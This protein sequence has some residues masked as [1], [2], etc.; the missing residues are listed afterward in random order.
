[1]NAVEALSAITDTLYDE[2]RAPHW[3]PALEGTS[4]NR[5]REE[6]Q[7]ILTDAEEVKKDP[8]G[9]AE[10][11]EDTEEGSISEDQDD[12]GSEV[13]KKATRLANRY[14]KLAEP[15]T[16]TQILYVKELVKTLA[17]R[18]TVGLPNPAELTTMSKADLSILIDKLK[19][20]RG[21]PV[22]IHGVFSHFDRRG[23]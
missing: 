23:N 17:Q 6:V 7:S 8:E 16:Y 3:N 14:L 9:W 22:Y 11:E 13:G 15:G 1:M 12:E 2:M 10:K 20:Q 21:E 4:G 19:K 5:E 18:G